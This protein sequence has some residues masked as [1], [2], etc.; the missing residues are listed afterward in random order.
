M[1]FKDDGLLVGFV[2][3][4]NVG[5]RIVGTLVGAEVLILGKRVDGL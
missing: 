3:D 1:G 4:A 5:L 2:I